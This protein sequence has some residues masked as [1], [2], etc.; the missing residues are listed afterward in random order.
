MSAVS[1]LVSLQ[2]QLLVSPG[3]PPGC[4]SSLTVVFSLQLA[5]AIQ[6]ALGSL[7]FSGDAALPS[8]PASRSSLSPTYEMS[9]AICYAG[10]WYE[11]HP[12]GGSRP[13]PCKEK[14]K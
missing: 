14:C 1:R 4:P 10:R 6:L 11:I 13:P 12:P 8:S 2:V 3:S 7:G 9:V 5:G